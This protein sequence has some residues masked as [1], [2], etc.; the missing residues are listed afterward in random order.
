MKAYETLKL[1]IIHFEAQDVVTA[2]VPEVDCICL[3]D[4][5]THKWNHF[6]SELNASCAASSHNHTC[7]DDTCYR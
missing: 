2:S 7:G 5:E 4:S 1:D 6:N 3:Y